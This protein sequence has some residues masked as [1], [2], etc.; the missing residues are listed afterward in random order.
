MPTTWTLHGGRPVPDPSKFPAGP[1]A[2]T[3]TGVEKVVLIAKARSPLNTPHYA[4]GRIDASHNHQ[5]CRRPEVVDDRAYAS[6]CVPVA[7]GQR[8]AARSEMIPA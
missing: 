8:P 3:S 2:V 6:R 5:A 1:C 7:V 4:L